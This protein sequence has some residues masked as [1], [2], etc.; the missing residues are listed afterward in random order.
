MFGPRNSLQI[1]QS[2]PGKL[3]WYT[4]AILATNKENF[5]LKTMKG[6]RRSTPCLANTSAIAL[7]ERK[8]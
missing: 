4:R 3:S 5:T 7:A 8:I 1:A 2:S 6:E